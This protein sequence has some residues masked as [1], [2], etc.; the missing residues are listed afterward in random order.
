M[1]SNIK[2]HIFN[3]DNISK[4]HHELIKVYDEDTNKSHM[5]E[6]CSVYL[7]I[8]V[9]ARDSEIVPPA[10]VPAHLTN[11]AVQIEL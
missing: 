6:Q 3:I 8:Q 5:L 11:S 4:I 7:H 1:I 9:Y 2:S 10:T